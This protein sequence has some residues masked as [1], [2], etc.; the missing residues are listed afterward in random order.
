MPTSSDR[1]AQKRAW[2]NAKAA[3]V[4]AEK[5]AV[6]LANHEELLRVN[7]LP[8]YRCGEFTG[9]YTQVDADVWER[10]RHET[11]YLHQHTGYAVVSNH[12]GLG[13]RFLHRWILALAGTGQQADHI[14]GDRLDNRRENLRACTSAE[15]AQNRTYPHPSGLPRGVTRQANGQY[16]AQAM[17]AGRMHTIGCYATPEEA[18]L[19]VSAWRAEHMPF[20]ADA[21][22][23]A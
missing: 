23:A 21:R 17:L 4:R 13:E 18:D 6:W 19:A 15:N 12:A 14:N 3:R 11:L 1:R 22:E 8:L 20:S 2:A 5:R 10:L 7:E 16:R 9:R